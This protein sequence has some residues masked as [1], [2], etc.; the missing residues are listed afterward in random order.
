MEEPDF[1]LC[2]L[3]DTEIEPSDCIENSDAVDG[4]LKKDT[5]PE[6]FKKKNNWEKICKECKWHGY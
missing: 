1:V 4:I 3:V 2:P 6:R 5:V